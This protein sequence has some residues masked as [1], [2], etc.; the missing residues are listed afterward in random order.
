MF[1]RSTRHPPQG[2]VESMTCW[3]ATVQFTCSPL[4]FYPL[5]S[6]TA[7]GH[8]LNDFFNKFIGKMVPVTKASLSCYLPTPPDS[9]AVVFTSFREPLICLGYQCNFRL[10]LLSP[11]PFPICRCTNNSFFLHWY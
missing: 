10:S 8:R 4:L 1:H 9:V 5:S 11:F 3:Q 6:P 7:L 2:S